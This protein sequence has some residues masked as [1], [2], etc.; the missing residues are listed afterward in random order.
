[1]DSIKSFAHGLMA[2]M[3]QMM[4]ALRV[5]L[6][7]A[8]W[9]GGLLMT[10]AV[11]VVLAHEQYS[12]GNVVLQ[13]MGEGLMLLGALVVL[14]GCIRGWWVLITVIPPADKGARK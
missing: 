6:L 10:G 5:L 1:M 13:L 9:A 12:D 3:A 2:G 7:T 8:K 4:P 11:L 14:V